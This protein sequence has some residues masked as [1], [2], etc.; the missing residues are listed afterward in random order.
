MI[1]L[2]YAA[3][4]KPSEKTLNIMR[5]TCLN[6]PGNPSSLHSLG[7][8]ARKQYNTLK[9]SL[10]TSL[11][12]T[13][14][15]IIITSTGTEA[16][17][18]AIKGTFFKHKD[19]TILTSTIE[20][21]ASINA[22]NFVKNQGGK[23]IEIPV[24]SEGFLDLEVLKETLKT[25]DVSLLTLIH[26][27]NEIGT[28]QP[29]EKIKSILNEAGVLLHLDM[30]Q[31]P[32]HQIVDFKALDVD[33]ASFSAHKFYGPRGVGLLYVKNPN[34][35]E[36]LIHG[37]KQE[38]ALRA[39]TENLS[40]LAGMEHAL[41]ES[42]SNIEQKESIIN[43]LAS[44]FLDT[45]DALNVDYYLNGPPLGNQRLNSVLNIGFKNID[46]QDLSFAL[47][48]EGIYVSTGSA[49]H[50]DQIEPS[51]VLKAI[52]TP[53]EYLCGCIRFSFSH[54]ESY[55]TLK[56]TATIIKRLIDSGDFEQ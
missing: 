22:L 49:C 16:I 14:K 37:G 18:H 36:S 6:Y 51:H 2:D 8:D 11:N 44:Y 29:I 39:G 28:I 54:K 42:W 20:H 4:T 23:V 43:D 17:N 34:A 21:H 38:N 24:D 25:H 26:A 13:V 45:L 15:N 3:T 50:S 35:L 56:K 48:E 33:F 30:V 40:G 7:I 9:K 1:Y 5:E 12:T 53:E 41:K 55:E 19:K 46:N 31:I 27:N 10:A 32:A 52:N 47:N